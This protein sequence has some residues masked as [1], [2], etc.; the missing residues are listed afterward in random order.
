MAREKEPMQLLPAV[1]GAY[2]RRGAREIFAVRT[3]DGS[4]NV[5]VARAPRPGQVE[6]IPLLRGVARAI[7][8]VR[9]PFRIYAASSRMRPQQ[10][11]RPSA[12]MTHVARS[13][14]LPRLTLT[15]LRT[16]FFIMLCVA[17]FAILPLLLELVIVPWPTPLR[18]VTLCVVRAGL[19]LAAV[20]GLS[21][22][23]FLKRVSMCRGAANKV[24]E[25]VRAR[26]RLTIESALTCR[27]TAAESDGA[28][29]LLLGLLLIVAGSALP[30]DFSDM[31]LRAAVRVL[32]ALAL[33]AV[34]NEILRPI[35]RRPDSP[36]HR[37][38]EWLQRTFT[39]EPHSE[40]LEVAI[41]AVKAARGEIHG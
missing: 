9:R 6:R 39:I 29:L 33:A 18:A 14:H 4:I 25:C 36:L 3:K 20:F 21:R 34:V 41:T 16:A 27:R 23:R 22:M 24:S 37:P 17:G 31:F 2:V 19:L 5:R 28:F 26:K 8:A 15:A 7:R 38:L 40:M 13:L 10:L 12:D 1:E 32:L 11:T 35:E 30:L